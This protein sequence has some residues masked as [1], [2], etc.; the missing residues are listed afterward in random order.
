M[1]REYFP[2]M[3]TAVA[4]RTINRPG[5]TWSDV[6][7]RVALGNS[8]LGPDSATE[9]RS[10][11]H[12]LS[13][14]S[15]LMSGRHL[16]H[17]DES[18]P[19]RAQTVFTNCSTAMFRF[20]TFQLL[21]SGSGVG[22]CY[23][24]AL[25]LID[26]S[27]MPTVVCVIDRNHKD[28]LVGYLTPED[29]RERYQ[30][31]MLVEH[32]VGDSRE[33]W[34][35]AVEI[36]ERMTFEGKDDHVL[37]LDFS[38]VRPAGAPI[39]GMQN[40]PASGPG[41][42]M[43]ALSN[44]AKLKG[45][46]LAPW[47]LAMLADHYLAECVLVGGA[48]RAARIATK[49][50]KDATIF[51]FI[52][53]KRPLEFRGK[54]RDEVEALRAGGGYY[55]SFLWSS[56][57]SVT[58]DAEF[59]ERVERTRSEIVTPTSGPADPLDLHAYK[60]WQMVMD[61]QYGDGTGEPGFL[62]VD[63]LE[64]DNT[65]I[66]QYLQSVYVEGA[67]EASRP[68]LTAMTERVLG[69]VYQH[70]VNP[71]VTG[72]TPI[73][74]KQGYRP[75]KALVGKTT[76]IWNGREWSSV[77]PFSTGV[78][79]LVRVHLSDGTSLTCTPQ[80]KFVVQNGY[81]TRPFK[82][83]AS[84]LQAG[85]RLAKF[86]M[87][88][89]EG[90]NNPDVDAYSQGFYSGD[91]TTDYNWSW[92]YEPKMVCSERLEGGVGTLTKYGRARWDHGDM[93]PK[94]FVPFDASVNYRINWLAGLI[95]ADGTVL[96][97]ES[98][99][100]IQVSSIDRDFLNNVRL[101]L[102]T[103][104]VQAKVTQSHDPQIKQIKGQ[105]FECQAV[106][107][108]LINCTDLYH[109]VEDMGLVSERMDLKQP[110]PQ[111]DARRFVTVDHVE[112]LGRAEETFC[113]TD[114]KNHT[115]TFNGIVTGNCGEISL[116]ILGGFC[117][118]AD[119]VP[120]HARN[121]DDA[122]DAFRASTRALMRVNLMD[123]I[124][125][126]EVERTNRIG[127]GITGLHEYMWDRFGLGF[128]DAI[129]HGDIGPLG[130]T[131]KAEPFWNMLKRFA[132]AVQDE[133]EKYAVVLGVNV[134]HTTRTMKPAGTTSKL[135]G[136]T[137][138]AHLPSMRKLLRWVQFRNDDPL[139]EEYR[140]RGYPVRKLVSYSGTTIVG[141]P[142][143]PVITT[144]G[145]GDKL[146]TAAEATVEEQFRWLK[147]LE[148][149]WIG[150][151]GGNQISYTLKYDP[152]KIDFPEF[153]RLMF[154]NVKQVRAVSVM[155]QI[156]NVSYEYVPEQAVSDEEYEAILAGI[157]EAMVEDVDKVHVECAGGACPIEWVKPNDVATANAA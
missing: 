90:N 25:M 123:S 86:Y 58:V 13:Q 76:E 38:D 79:P 52:E 135:F 131:K 88:V 70:I 132:D 12:H 146:V 19:E 129:A 9:Y 115:G 77:T 34:S 72:D 121:D 111:R 39:R 143:A 74:T 40:R 134:P 151:K 15:T 4:D 110:L 130:I 65:G 152:E 145:M 28:Q 107:R 81:R 154:E 109:L 53:V 95:D 136:L 21:L 26:W 6:A 89:V 98:G 144:L 51:D 35:G 78:N 54:T 60:V 36:M 2:G 33:G 125:R 66:E 7:H 157:A 64:I 141:F 122:E 16:Q 22:G 148:H 48:R 55:E 140:A 68:M 75:I 120:Y 106:Y 85:T 11:H 32:R 102:T 147:L 93:L 82:V 126:K 138:A 103:L 20:I 30:G 50:W 56:N 17:G 113:F 124:Y 96:R 49:Y 108:L 84:E 83:G 27:K 31:Q 92:V 127:V 87:P 44:V 5:E 80:H 47:N 117:V 91:G 1:T 100:A 94:D 105:D 14:A 8:L 118:I 97:Y 104:G 116:H 3:G 46:S 69:H 67:D 150:E 73:L 99:K 139:V 112:R 156:N 37:L 149:Y 153:E 62:N 23:D 29:A 57:N 155:P 101:M 59:W 45:S 61:C 71:C 10:L 133:A 128:R 114:P 41:P 63:K 24:D 142:T 43:H 42:L 119:V 137:E 18:Q